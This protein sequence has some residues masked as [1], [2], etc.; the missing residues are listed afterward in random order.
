[1]AYWLLKSEPE[2]YAWDDLCREQVGTWDGVRNHLAK[3]NLKSMRPGDQALFYHSVSQK[4]VVGIME[5]RSKAFND[6]TAEPGQP[7][8]AVKVRP[9][10]PLKRPVT[11]HEI[12]SDPQFEGL[13]LL[14]HTRLSVIP[15]SKAHFDAILARAQRPAP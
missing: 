10:R 8:V 13:A 12:K 1:M 14:T 15:L 9:I 5:I 7:W 11:L 3:L 4:A 6:P 2:T